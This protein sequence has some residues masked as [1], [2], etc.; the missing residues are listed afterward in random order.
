MH[1]LVLTG[2][3]RA[4]SSRVRGGCPPWSCCVFGHVLCVA[5]VSQFEESHHYVVTCPSPD[6]VLRAGDCVFVLATAMP[7]GAMK[8]FE[9]P[10]D[11]AG[12]AGALFSALHR[13][14]S[15]S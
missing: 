10:V 6:T 14:R 4:W 12:A 15:H 1:S 13:Q 9:V 2:T 7:E 3:K 8:R 11:N 5:G